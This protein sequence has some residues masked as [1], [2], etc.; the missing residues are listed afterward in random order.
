MALLVPLFRW[1]DWV[2]DLS[3][4]HLYGMPLTSGVFWTGLWVMLG[5]MV[6]GFGGATLAMSRREVGR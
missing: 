3:L 1:P 5:I 4:L 2:L 6:I